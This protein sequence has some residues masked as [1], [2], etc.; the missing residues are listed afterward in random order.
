LRDCKYEKKNRKHTFLP[1]WEKEFTWLKNTE[2]GMV[3]AI[4]SK[5]E[6]IVVYIITIEQKNYIN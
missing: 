6:H 2:K 5:H 1:G 3:Y 4:C